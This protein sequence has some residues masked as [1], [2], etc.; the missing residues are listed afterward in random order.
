M[1]I[2]KEKST[3]IFANHDPGCAI[4]LLLLVAL[5]A[6]VGAYLWWDKTEAEPVTA[7]QFSMEAPKL[8]V[9]SDWSPATS[10]ESRFRLD[11]FR[12]VSIDGV[13]AVEYDL[14][15]DGGVGIA[16]LPLQK[17]SESIASTEN[18]IDYTPPAE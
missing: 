3:S 12:Y 2:A 1:K 8:E 11:R 6:G 9:L 5:V 17:S 13:K 4:V 18:P 7:Q 16:F 14:N 15:M 10:K